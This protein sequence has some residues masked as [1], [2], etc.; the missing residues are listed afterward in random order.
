MTSPLSTLVFI[1]FAAAMFA[2]SFR[3]IRRASR[4]DR[5]IAG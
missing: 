5:H 4:N 2:V 1:V 3:V